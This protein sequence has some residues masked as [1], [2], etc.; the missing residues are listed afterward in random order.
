[1]DMI[2]YAGHAAGAI[3]P[4]R[5]FR[6]RLATLLSRLARAHKARRDFQA[7]RSANDHIL[8]DIGVTRA[9]IDI[10]LAAPFWV[11]PCDRIQG[12]RRT[13]RR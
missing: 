8:D 1:M 12:R 5:A 13:F 11:N 6:H 3:E 9:Q 7:L 10:A 4:P 2:T